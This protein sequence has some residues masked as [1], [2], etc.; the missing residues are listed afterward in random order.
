[1][2]TWHVFVP[3]L[4]AVCVDPPPLNTQV[5]GHLPFRGPDKAARFQAEAQ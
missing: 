5:H 3:D 2:P 4:P 1:M